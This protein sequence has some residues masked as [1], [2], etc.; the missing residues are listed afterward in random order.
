MKFSSTIVDLKI[1]T[2]CILNCLGS[3][4]KWVWCYQCQ[5][6]ECYQ[7][8]YDVNE[9]QF[10]HHQNYMQMPEM[11][12]CF[13]STFEVLL[14]IQCQWRKSFYNKEIGHGEPKI[15]SFVNLC[16]FFF[17]R[18]GN[19]DTAFSSDSVEINLKIRWRNSQKFHGNLNE[20]IKTYDPYR[21]IF[22]KV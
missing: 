1:W 18:R 16:V 19:T 17:A 2:W 9:L 8:V 6:V 10:F 4:K 15:Q 3:E 5:C 7:R 14:Q 12:H 13:V 11:W 20:F 22:L 21:W